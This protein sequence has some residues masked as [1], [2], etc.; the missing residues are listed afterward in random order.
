MIRLPIDESNVWVVRAFAPVLKAK[1][2][3]SVEPGKKLKDGAFITILK[4]FKTDPTCA[5]VV[6]KAGAE[7]SSESRE[8]NGEDVKDVVRNVGEG[9]QA[10]MF[11][12]F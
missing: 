5:S 10:Y 11:G 2:W 1:I 8:H 7:F 4:E 9:V 12:R 3:V 6:G